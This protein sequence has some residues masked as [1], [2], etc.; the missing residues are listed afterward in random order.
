MLP[1]FLGRKQ[2]KQRPYLA[3]YVVV[4]GR[5]RGEGYMPDK[6]AEKTDNPNL[7]VTQFQ[8]ECLEIKYFGENG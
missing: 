4:E 5:G 7:A 6:H 2:G 3:L 1:V 8:K